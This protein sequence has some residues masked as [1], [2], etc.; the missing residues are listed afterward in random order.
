MSGEEW[1]LII[2]TLLTQMAV[3]AF[4]MLVF[5]RSFL[6]K[7]AGSQTAA[8]VTKLGIFAVGP[9]MVVALLASLFHLGSPAL[10]F[11]AVGNLGTSWLSREILF[12]GL[13]LF[14][15]IVSFYMYKNENAGT[16][17]G[18]VTAIVGLLAIYSMAGIYGVS[19]K[20]AWAHPNTFVSFFGTTFL[21]GSLATGAAVA[22][23]IKGSE[24]AGTVALSVMQKVSVVAVVAIAVQLVY[25]PVYLV[26]LV[27]GGQA[28]QTSAQL[29]AETYRFQLVLRWLLSIIGGVILAWVLYREATKEQAVPVKIVYLA[30]VTV[31]VGE[32]IGRYLFYASAVSITVG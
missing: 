15:W 31:L 25:L 20:P 19:I 3:G 18:W 16:G 22:Y 29:L 17:L 23:S 8:Q 4:V 21:L 24:L 26:G 9:V 14:L 2:F 5:I 32:I 13:F 1:A 11:R 30:L 10:A 27:G 6:A 7:E 12:S 28:A